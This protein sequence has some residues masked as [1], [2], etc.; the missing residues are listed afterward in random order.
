MTCVFEYLTVGVL[1]HKSGFETIYVFA[2]N[3]RLNLFF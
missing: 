3:K 1:I 2:N